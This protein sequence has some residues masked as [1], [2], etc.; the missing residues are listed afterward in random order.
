MFVV[1]PTGRSYTA[2][3][4]NE[5][6]RRCTCEKCGTE[7][8]YNFTV[9]G[10]G[11]G[12]SPLWVRNKAAGEDAKTRAVADMEKNA[13]S[14]FPPVACPKCNHIQAQM[15]QYYRRTR[16]ARLHLWSWIALVFIV[17]ISVI[18]MVVVGSLAMLRSPVYWGFVLTPAALIAAIRLLR[19]YLNPKLAS[20]VAPERAPAS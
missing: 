5:Y 8:T 17:S 1:I 19:R 7:F 12:S 10:S 11:Q 4:K 16:F 20:P 15:L 13:Q 3:V 18:A 2:T 9:S 14:A 6:T